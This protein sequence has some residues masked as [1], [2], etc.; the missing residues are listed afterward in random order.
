MIAMFEYTAEE[1]DFLYSAVEEAVANHTH[2]SNSDMNK[3]SKFIHAGDFYLD[4]VAANG[5]LFTFNGLKWVDTDGTIYVCM[6][7]PHQNKDIPWPVW[8]PVITVDDRTHSSSG[9]LQMIRKENRYIGTGTGWEMR[10][11]KKDEAEEK[12]TYDFCM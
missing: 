2:I 7:Q 6:I 4:S 9:Q 1:I 8:E 5:L 12:S 10:R 11:L 3:I